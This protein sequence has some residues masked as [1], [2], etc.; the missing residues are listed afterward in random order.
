MTGEGGVEKES[1]WFTR[2]EHHPVGQDKL[3]DVSVRTEVK[4]GRVFYSFP[5]NEATCSCGWL[6][7]PFDPIPCGRTALETLIEEAS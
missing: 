6:N 1:R 3:Y 7:P 2:C 5:I 4:D